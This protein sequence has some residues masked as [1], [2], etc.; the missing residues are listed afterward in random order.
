L[1]VRGSFTR[2]VRRVR[3]N[4]RVKPGVNV[5][6]RVKSVT[7]QPLGLTVT[8]VTA[9]PSGTHTRAMG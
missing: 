3:V 5:S 7:G 6:V 9:A 8:Q 1:P 2:R 4:P